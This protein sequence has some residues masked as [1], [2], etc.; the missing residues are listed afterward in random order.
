MARQT[1]QATLEQSSVSGSLMKSLIGMK[2]QT[3][4]IEEV[5]G[6]IDNQSSKISELYEKLN[7]H[8]GSFK[9]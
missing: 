4:I 6:I 9:V 5:S 8:V 1:S 7:T 2:E 3:D